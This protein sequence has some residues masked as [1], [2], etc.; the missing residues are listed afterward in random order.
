MF[1]PG[2]LID[3]QYRLE[4]KLG[5]GALGVVYRARHLPSGEALGLKLMLPEASRT[6]L[7]RARFA[8]EAELGQAVRHPGLVGVYGVG[9]HR[10]PS[11][12]HATT[13]Y[14]VTELMTGETLDVVLLRLRRLPVGTAIALVRDLAHALEAVHARGI[15][16]RDVK[17]ANVFMHQP[18][19]GPRVAKLFDFGVATGLGAPALDASEGADPANASIVGSPA[20]LSPERL[21]GALEVDPRADVWALGAILYRALAG[22]L[23]FSAEGGVAGIARAIREEP[24]RPLGDHVPGLSA[25]ITSLVDACLAKRPDARLRSAAAVADA[26]DDALPTTEAPWLEHLRVLALEAVQPE[27]AFGARDPAR[28][29][30][31]TRTWDEDP[32]FRLPAAAE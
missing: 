11:A 25:R 13:P 20:Y 5:Q 3:G 9:L 22:A 16:H 23:P 12:P 19:R 4:R 14:L 29:R 31:L 2:S 1:V 18:D 8:A 28:L 17:P 15:V 26:L 10:A 32:V 24:H 21:D 7:S 27:A 6:L 30:R